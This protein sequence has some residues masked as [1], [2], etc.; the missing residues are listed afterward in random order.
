MFGTPE[1]FKPEH[2]FSRGVNDREAQV[3]PGGRGLAW[4]FPAGKGQARQQ[5]PLNH[6]W[7]FRFPY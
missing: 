7:I 5:R 3:S 4:E 6:P 2:L 1:G